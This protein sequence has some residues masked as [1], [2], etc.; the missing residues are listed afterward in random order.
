MSNA[1]ATLH[2]KEVDYL[3]RFSAK[4]DQIANDANT[5]RT[6]FTEGM[7]EMCAMQQQEILR[8]N[9]IIRDNTVI[10]ERHPVSVSVATTMRPNGTTRE[11]WFAVASDKSLWLMSN[12][13]GPQHRRW[14]RVPG[15]P[16]AADE[17][18]GDR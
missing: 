17:A 3:A 8:L 12:E 15:L 13:S 2:A 11:V 16:Q 1:V 10:P 7:A 6:K 18:D 9:R 4:Q 5:G 14:E